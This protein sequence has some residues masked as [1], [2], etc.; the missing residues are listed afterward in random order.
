[1]S[2]KTFVVLPAYNEEQA[3]PRLLAKLAPLYIE[4]R[5]G[6]RVLIVDDGSR[7]HTAEVA[8][9]WGAPVELVSHPHNMGLGAAIRTGLTHATR[10]A[11]PDD[12]IVTMDADDTHMP[13][14]VPRMVQI[15][16]EGYDLVIASRYQPGSR[17]LG[18]SAARRFLSWGAGWLFQIALPMQGV[19]DYTSGF[20]AYRAGLVQRALERW[21][22]RL[23]DRNDF[24]SMPRLLLR[25]RRLGA[26]TVEV[27]MVLRYDLK[28]SV[29]KMRVGGNVAANLKLIV[30]ELYEGGR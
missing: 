8:R 29:S 16:G 6:G 7:D 30:Q 11:A 12:A 26:I 5:L 13:G 2:T 18:V 3:L 28:P 1:M 4:G 19:R 9:N 14:L 17:T 15:L 22:E 10:L 25:M 20:R 27:P 21:G 24:S 23:I